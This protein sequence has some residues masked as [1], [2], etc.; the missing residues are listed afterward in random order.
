MRYSDPVNADGKTRLYEAC[1]GPFMTEQEIVELIDLHPEEINQQ[2][3]RPKRFASVNSSANI[4]F[5]G[6]N[7]GDTPLH[8]AVEMNKLAVVKKLLSVG[9]NPNIENTEG[10]TPIYQAIK[11][12]NP[13]MV[14]ELLK[15]GAKVNIQNHDFDTPMMVATDIA[16]ENADRF[17]A[18]DLKKIV[19]LIEKAEKAKMII[20]A[21]ETQ[22]FSKSMFDRF[23]SMMN[24]KFSSPIKTPIVKVDHKEELII[25]TK[26]SPPLPD[27]KI[28][29]KFLK[30]D[31]DFEKTPKT[32]PMSSGSLTPVS[33]PIIKVGRERVK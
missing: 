13:L 19:K 18:K 32:D 12:M 28:L 6:Y 33:S 25:K 16:D 1:S 20:D 4:D 31:V 8:A 30:E 29:E 21:Q 5:S 7:I 11:S 15:A 10:D 17:Y 26:K 27:V 24:R 22:Q 3:Q 2:V 23:K 9:A 14:E